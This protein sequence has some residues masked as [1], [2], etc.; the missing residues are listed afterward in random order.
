MAM[1]IKKVHHV[2]YRCVDAKQ[3]AEW[4]QKY[5]GMK[6]ILAIAED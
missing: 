3:T 6:F 4:Y 2:A 5:L 1:L